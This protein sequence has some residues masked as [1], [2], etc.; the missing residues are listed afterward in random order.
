MD[1]SKGLLDR[2]NLNFQTF[3]FTFWLLAVEGNSYN[4]LL[5]LYQIEK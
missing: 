2:V 4:F 1:A 3:P 5:L